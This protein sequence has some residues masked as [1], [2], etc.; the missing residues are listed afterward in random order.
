[1]KNLFKDTLLKKILIVL[2]FSIGVMLFL[3]FTIWYSELATAEFFM[4]YIGKILISGSQPNILEFYLSSPFP[5]LITGLFSKISESSNIRIFFALLGFMS[6][7]FYYKFTLNNVF[8]KR[9][10]IITLILFAIQSTHI[11]MSKF[12]SADIIAFTL[13]AISIWYASKLLKNK[14]NTSS[15]LI[16]SLIYFLSIIS[17]Y[18]LILFLPLIAIVI[19][20]ND[21]RNGLIFLSVT[22]LLT[23][24]Y[25]ILEWQLISKQIM[26]FINFQVDAGLFLGNLESNLYYL[27]AILIIYILLFSYRIKLGIP[28]NNLIIFSIFASIMPLFNL[29]LINNYQSYFNLTYSLMFLILYIGVLF[30]E[31]L[32]QGRSMVFAIS[33]VFLVL[34][35][36]S[37]Y[38]VS[39]FEQ[40]QVK[41]NKD[42]IEKQL[43]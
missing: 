33:F 17:Y 1:M 31:F 13:F 5:A 16:L 37:F 34:T 28:L 32:K 7:F 18:P 11:F 36:I 40:I 6:L 10:A 39:K 25:A 43:K 35:A 20:L 26:Y 4:I 9:S 29:F 27:S 22:L 15:Y 24:L 3:R 38:H 21:K 41:F 42:S 2:L 23:L 19:L 8:E 14:S 12:V 30:K